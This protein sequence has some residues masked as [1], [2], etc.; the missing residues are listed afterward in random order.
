MNNSSN[1]NGATWDIVY[2]T[3][4]KTVSLDLTAAASSPYNIKYN[5]YVCFL[6]ILL[7]FLTTLLLVSL[8]KLKCFTNA[9]TINSVNTELN[10]IEGT[11][12]ASAY[13]QP[14]K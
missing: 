7:K 11:V 8:K 4:A 6:K 9:A 10:K 5:N 14:I 1:F 2:D 13:A 3:T 12:F